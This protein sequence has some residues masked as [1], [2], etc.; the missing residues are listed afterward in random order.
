[1]FQIKGL[2]TTMKAVRFHACGGP[3]VLRYEDVPAPDAGPG[4]LL[5]RVQAA[6]VNPVDWKTR[7]GRTGL[8]RRFPFTPGWDV[9][10]VV[11]RIGAGVAG[12]ARGDEVFGLVRFPEEG[13]AYAE[14]CAAP[15]AHL[16]RK[17]ASVSHAT[18]AAVPLVALTAWQALF[19]VAALRAGQTVLV[20]AAAG[21]VGHVA[22]Q[23]AKRA[24]ARVVGTGSARSRDLLVGLGVDE[25][26]D[27][28]A[29]RFE[30]R[31]RDVDVVL[32][33]LAGETRDR[34]WAVLRD[35]GM[36]VSIVGGPF[37]VPEAHRGRCRGRWMMVQPSAPQLEQ[38]ARALEGGS[39]RVAIERTL[40]LAEAA[41]AHR[42]SEAGHVRGKLVLEVAA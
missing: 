34:S 28:E 2:T 18:A 8:A 17:P 29:A 22:V 3:E 32:D 38:I 23:L 30:E 15:A 10:G 12:F 13:A 20:H 5:V 36:V 21:G 6:S 26:V 9:S 11:E 24:G 41:E 33:P 1:M 27:R 7:Q 4:E 42:L 35:G 16:V 40:P 37:E 19:D 25:F 31:A 14:R 39:L